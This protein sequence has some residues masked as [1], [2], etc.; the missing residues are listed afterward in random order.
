MTSTLRLALARGNNCAL[1]RCPAKDGHS[2]NNI[3]NRHFEQEFLRSHLGKVTFGRGS[4]NEESFVTQRKGEWIR[5]LELCDQA[6]RS[7]TDLNKSQL[8]ELLQLYRKASRDLAV[9]R[10]ISTSPSL[11]RYLNDITAKAYSVVYRQPRESFGKVVSMAVIQSVQTVRRR[12]YFVLA[13]ASLF[14]GSAVL[15]L[16]LCQF[17]P[18]MHGYFVPAAMDRVF[19]QWKNGSFEERSGSQSAFMWTFY[20][21]HNPMVAIITGSV[22]AATFGFASVFMIL[23][24]GAVMGSLASEVIPV[25]R[26]DY[27]LSSILPHGV[28]EITGLLLSGACGLLLGWS[29]I[30]PGR[31]TRGQSL[32]AVGKDAITLLA[33]SMVM[34]FIAAP[35]EGFFSFNR[36][37]PG[38][39]KTCVGL[40]SL[41]LWLIF[42]STFAR[43]KDT[44]PPTEDWL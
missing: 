19:D 14:L 12:K 42:W 3:G 13:S 17:S 5:L 6:D 33:T 30:N 7:P 2:P 10:T 34:M 39:V 41:T 22:G 24:N 38:W 29:L 4:M 44:P 21:S 27:L 25:H 36:H 40:T 35:I 8:I 16:L 26:L 23:S 20:A 32:R 15:V 1:D 43:D 31:L 18:A 28:P 37:V 9:A 11:I